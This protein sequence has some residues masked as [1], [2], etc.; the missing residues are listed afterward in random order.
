MTFTP[1]HCPNPA[2]PSNHGRAFSF[3]RRGFYHRK[4]DGKR[5]AQFQ[6]RA[7]HKYGSSQTFRV[8]YRFRRPELDVLVASHLVS[9]TTIRQTAR[10]L[11]CRRETV[12]TRLARF[13]IHGWVYH[14]KQLLGLRA[15][16][17]LTGDFQLDELETFE[18]DRRLSPVTLPVLIHQDSRLILH[19]TAGSMA[20]RGNLTAY[21]ESRR[22]EREKVTG[23]RTSESA[24]CVTECFKLLKDLVVEPTRSTLKTDEKQLYASLLRRMDL[25]IRHER[26]ISTAPRTTRNPLFPINHTLAMLRDGVSRL[27]R[28]NWG[29]SKMRQ[30]LTLH[31][32]LYIAWK[33]Y[34]RRRFNRDRPE[35]SPGQW[36]GAHSAAATMMEFL[37]WRVFPWRWKGLPQSPSWAA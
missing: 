29:A 27:V 15:K 32:G 16:G 22:I 31:L 3:H 30:R 19:A 9:K 5:V 33:N 18:A 10:I 28:R 12:E 34:V 6:C 35:Q 7:C 36:V 1:E 20:A 8:N 37:R 13:G 25:P 26:T 17:G 4:C 21:D 24:A 11:G 23:R 14:T 2:C